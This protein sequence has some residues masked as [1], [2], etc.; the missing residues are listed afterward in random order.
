MEYGRLDCIDLTYSVEAS[1][2]RG[3]RIFMETRRRL[4]FATITLHPIADARCEYSPR[5]TRIRGEK[6]GKRD[7]PDRWYAGAHSL[8]SKLPLTGVQ[9]REKSEGKRRIVYQRTRDE[10]DAGHTSCRGKDFRFMDRGYCGERL[11]VPWK[12]QAERLATTL[13]DEDRGIPAS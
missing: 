13:F 12:H 10:R 8:P 5:D 7:P 2:Y 9:Y 3:A 11:P 1:R 6:E 4:A